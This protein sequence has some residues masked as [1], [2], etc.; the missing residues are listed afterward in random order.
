MKHAHIFKK[1]YIIGIV[2]IGGIKNVWEERVLKVWK[3]WITIIKQFQWKNTVDKNITQ[4]NTV[5][6]IHC[7]KNLE[8]ILLFQIIQ[9]YI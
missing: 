4:N 2:A 3:M 1:I 5:L 6:T 9:Y 8:A 7:Q